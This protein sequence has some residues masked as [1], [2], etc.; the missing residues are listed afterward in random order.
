MVNENPSLVRDLMTVGVD[1]CKTDTPVLDLA[2]LMLQK[3]LEAV[4]VLDEDGCA[5]GVVSLEELS[6]LYGR[7]AEAGQAALEGLTAS[8]V[9]REGVPQVPPDIPLAAAAQ[10]MHDQGVRAVFLMHHA[11]GIEYPAG[12]LTY[13]HLI[14]HMTAKDSAELRDLGI[15]ADRTS[16]LDAFIKR[17]DDARKNSGRK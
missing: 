5:Q 9:M 12:V 14:R 8:A 2:R 1:T 16:P 6:Q 3:K 11:G 17:R 7:F 15:T 10:M 4:V 13:T